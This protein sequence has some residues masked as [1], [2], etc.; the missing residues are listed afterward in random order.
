MSLKTFLASKAKDTPPAKT[1]S[2]ERSISVEKRTTGSVLVKEQVIAFVGNQ[3]KERRADVK[4]MRFIAS[5]MGKFLSAEQE[6]AISNDALAY[7]VDVYVDRLALRAKSGALLAE[8]ELLDRE[9]KDFNKRLQVELSKLSV[10]GVKVL[11]KDAA[12]RLVA[13]CILGKP[14]RFTL[15]QRS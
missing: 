1:K 9:V 13:T 14:R 7:L 5:I 3:A 4:A 2:T 15:P 12:K 8:L 11:D 6:F 10:A